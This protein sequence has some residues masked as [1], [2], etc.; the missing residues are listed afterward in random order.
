MVSETSA[1]DTSGQ[2]L[3]FFSAEKLKIKVTQ[4]VPGA[5]AEVG[6]LISVSESDHE[7]IFIQDSVWQDCVL[8]N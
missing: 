7:R 2:V 5:Y 4:M 6:F 3:L 1:R 8:S